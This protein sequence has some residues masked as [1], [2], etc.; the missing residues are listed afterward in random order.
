M[1]KR[2]K[3]SLPQAQFRKWSVPLGEMV[4]VAAVLGFLG[5][6]LVPAVV[7]ARSIQPDKLPLSHFEQWIERNGSLVFF[8]LFPGLPLITLFAAICLRSCAPS[9]LLP[10][11]PWWKPLRDD[12]FTK[13]DRHGGG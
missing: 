3:D 9:W 11:L 5:G 7:A 2:E 8:L 6:L 10:Y 4:I 12:A 13:R 1:K